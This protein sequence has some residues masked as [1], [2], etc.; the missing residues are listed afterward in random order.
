VSRGLV[1]HLM[2]SD[3]YLRTFT[4][5]YEVILITNKKKKIGY[6]QRLMELIQMGL[7]TLAS[8]PLFTSISGSLGTQT[9][10]V[11]T[12]TALTQP[13]GISQARLSPNLQ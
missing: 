12:P 13:S 11:V 7:R 2:T 3:E 1:D 4:R 10:S 6:F 8:S 5:R 9:H